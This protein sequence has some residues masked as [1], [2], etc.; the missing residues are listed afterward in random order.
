MKSPRL[1]RALLAPALAAPLALGPVGC[2]PDLAVNAVRAIVVGAVATG[3]VAVAVTRVHAARSAA[4]DVER[5]QLE[6]EALKKDGRVVT[7]S[8]TLTA[9]QVKKI[10]ETGKVKVQL[11]DGTEKELPV[12]IRP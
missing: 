10:R 2:S 6:I 4:L 5:K 7:T 11:D 1:L 3:V 8:T 12:S 9:E